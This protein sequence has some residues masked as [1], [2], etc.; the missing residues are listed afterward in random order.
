[1]LIMVLS[2]CAGGLK[3][4]TALPASEFSAHAGNRRTAFAALYTDR[5]IAGLDKD[6]SMG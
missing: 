1:L 5:T 2:G 6:E 4:S 3:I